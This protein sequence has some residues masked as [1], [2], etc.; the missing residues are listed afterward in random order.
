MAITA[1]RGVRTPTAPGSA[2]AAQR[3]AAAALAVQSQYD[4]AT[5]LF[6]TGGGNCWW[7]SANELTALSDYGRRAQA[8]TYLA[9]LATTYARAG[10]RGPQGAAMGPFLDAWND[11]DGWWGL[12]WVAA[13]R[14]A[15]PSEPVQA[16]AYLQRAEAIFTYL[17]GQW[18]TAACGGGL[19]QNLKPTHTKDAITNELFLSLAAE[20]YQLTGQANYRTWALREWTWFQASGLMGRD[21]LVVDHL[22]PGTCRPQG[23][24]YWT[25]TQGV[26]LGGLATLSQDLGPSDPALA[27]KALAQAEAVAECVTQPACGGAVRPPLL[28]A[29]GILTEPCRTTPCTYAPA[30]QFKGVFVRNLGILNRRSNGRYSAFL[31]ANARS[32]WDHRNAQ[33]RFGFYWDAPPTFYLPADAAAPIDGAALDLLTTQ[34]P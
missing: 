6:C 5:G 1:C 4:G 25:Y 8:S 21:H 9:D 15:R 27:S 12:A 30:Y 32:L 23:T 17:T 31:A 10:T 3:A 24:Q 22:A 34:L 20:L 7:W 14:Y 33:G 11:D 13:Y 16:K 2:T 26:I 18:D 19:Y 29:R 28:D